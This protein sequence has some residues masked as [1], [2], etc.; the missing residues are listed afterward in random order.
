MDYLLRKRRFDQALIVN[1]Y[2]LKTIILMNI[3]SHG[4][5]GSWFF[6]LQKL[7]LIL[8]EEFIMKKK[9]IALTMVGA[10]SVGAI[11][12]TAGTLSYYKGTGYTN[13]ISPKLDEMVNKV[14]TYEANE[15]TLLGK[16]AG[17]KDDAANKIN[18]ANDVISERE[19]DIANLKDQKV[20]LE[21]EVAK[22]TKDLEAVNTELNGTKDTLASTQGELESTKTDLNA[23]KEQL[24][25]RI[26][27]LNNKIADLD[28]KEKLLTDAN[29]E[30][31]VLKSEKS[32]LQYQLNKANA[33]FDKL[34][35]AIMKT[36][37]EIK[38]NEPADI[39]KVDTTVPEVKEGSGNKE[40]QGNQGNHGNKENQGNQG[41]QNQQ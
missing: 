32:Q 16:I 35:P 25:A 7:K 28:A 39:S 22:L 29:K 2:L 3:L 21:S 15:N 26:A 36:V 5:L 18:H 11:G 10:L 30:K 9:I 37:N 24:A 8:L 20:N 27:D 38:K 14:K 19:S 40:H 1:F 13:Y 34:D 31:E 6:A 41:N 12:A 17:M 23:T 33:E 4:P